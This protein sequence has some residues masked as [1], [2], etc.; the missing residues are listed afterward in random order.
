MGG[1][2]T[3]LISIADEP[4]DDDDVRLRKRVGVIAG[5]VTVIAPLSVPFETPNLPASWIPA[6]G[7]SVFSAVNLLVLARSRNLSRYVIAL[8][9]GGVAFVPI[10]NTLGGG[11]M[12]ASFGLVWAFMVP[13]YAILAL[14]A[15]REPHGSSCSWRCSSEW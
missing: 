4:S 3:R 15:R 2:A 13:A 7:L 10:A 6:I 5:Y 14:G 8:L 1:L 11:V 9:L 12:G